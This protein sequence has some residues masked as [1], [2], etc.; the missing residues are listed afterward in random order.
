MGSEMKNR[1]PRKTPLLPCLAK[2]HCC[3]AP[4]RPV[5]VVKIAGQN[6]NHTF[7]FMNGD[8]DYEKCKCFC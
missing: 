2:Y 6:E 3:P 5:E 7:N 8:D 1:L 4:S